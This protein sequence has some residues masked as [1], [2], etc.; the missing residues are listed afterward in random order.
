MKRTTA[1]AITISVLTIAGFVSL[2]Q[3]AFCLW[4]TAHPLYRSPEWQARF[5]LRFGTTVVIGL[6]WVCSI[7]WLRRRRRRHGNN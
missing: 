5:Y 3:T 6:A 7:L 4:M 1:P 2:Y